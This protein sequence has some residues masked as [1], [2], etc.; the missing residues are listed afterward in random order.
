VVVF[1]DKQTR[2]VKGLRG[3]W[4]FTGASTSDLVFFAFSHY[5]VFSWVFGRSFPFGSV[6]RIYF[7]VVF[8]TRALGVGSRP[9]VFLPWFPPPRRWVGM[10]GSLLRPYPYRCVLFLFLLLRPSGSARNKI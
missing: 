5:W 1:G 8:S 2:I 10:G 3:G 4:A 9:G 6:F 7:V